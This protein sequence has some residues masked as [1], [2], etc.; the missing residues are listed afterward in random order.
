M[1]PAR[2]GTVQVRRRARRV[3]AQHLGQDA[4]GL[5]RVARFGQPETI[6]VQGREQV[7]ILAGGI[8]LAVV[9]LH[10]EAAQVC[11]RAVELG[12]LRAREGAR[13]L[14]QRAERGGYVDGRLI[15]ETDF[16]RKRLHAHGVIGQG[17]AQGDKRLRLPGLV[18]G[19]ISGHDGQR[20]I[21]M[22]RGGNALGIHQEAI[23]LRVV[24]TAIGIAHPVNRFGVARGADHHAFFPR[25]TPLGRVDR[26]RLRTEIQA[27]FLARAARIPVQVQPVFHLPDHDGVLDVLG[28]PGTAFRLAQ[29][30]ARQPNGLDHGADIG[31]HGGLR[32]GR[33]A[34][35]RDQNGA[36]QT[37]NCGMKALHAGRE[38][39]GIGDAD[40]TPRA[41]YPR[42]CPESILS[43][44]SPEWSVFR[45]IFRNITTSL[46]A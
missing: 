34:S 25:S 13:N 9:L 26:K 32:R 2:I 36:E 27:E 1:L 35:Q 22:D 45:Y 23:G 37:G 6:V 42:V 18:P 24:G 28:T 15:F 31:R 5:R 8:D 40:D 41:K 10:D 11:Q 3:T 30:V 14:M 21:G 33:H 44:I 17:R 38:Y 43:T 46:T 19:P 12:R 4:V 7:G 16:G 20:R 39:Q 29:R